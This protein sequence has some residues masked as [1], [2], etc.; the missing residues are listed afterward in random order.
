MQ[1]VSPVRAVRIKRALGPKSFISLAKHGLQYLATV[2]PEDARFLSRRTVQLN[3]HLGLLPAAW[4]VSRGC[5]LYRVGY[6]GWT[7]ALEPRV[8]QEARISWRGVEFQLIN[9][10]LPFS[11]LLRNKNLTRLQAFLQGQ[12]VILAGDLNATPKDLFLNDLVL[13]GGLS[14]AGSHEA[15]HDSGRRIDYV[16]FGGG[17]REAGYSLEKSASDHR[18]VRATLE[19]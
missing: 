3:G 15:T 7:D 1:E 11:P 19:V 10:H 4:S 13:A 17:F 16:M 8:A 5:A 12:N 6:T 2:L 9:T 18:L 14:V